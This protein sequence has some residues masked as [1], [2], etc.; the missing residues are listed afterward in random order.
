MSQTGPTTTRNWNQEAWCVVQP[1]DVPAQL[2][3]R[4]L[5]RRID[6]SANAAGTSMTT[7]GG[8]GTSELTNGPPFGWNVLNAKDSGT[9][10]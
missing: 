8:N 2:M 10:L 7:V 9:E 5:V 4:F 1:R 3:I 6:T